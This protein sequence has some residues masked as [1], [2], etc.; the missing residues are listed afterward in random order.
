MEEYCE[1]FN[2]VYNAIPQD[3][4]PSPSLYLIDFPDG[5]DVDMEYQLRERDSETLE[6][7]QDNAIKVEDNILAKKA[8]LKSKRRV[9]IK[10][11]PSTFVVDHKIDNLVG[12]VNQMMQRV[13]DQTQVR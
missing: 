7:M 12:V 13:I 11:E 10:E 4:K 3:I 8:K 9:T 6:E 2:T 1:R 5:F